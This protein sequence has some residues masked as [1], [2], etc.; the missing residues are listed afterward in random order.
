MQNSTTS[1]QSLQSPRDA[2]STVMWQSDDPGTRRHLR[3]FSKASAV[4]TASLPETRLRVMPRNA[5]LCGKSRVLPR[6][7]R[8]G[9]RFPGRELGDALAHAVDEPIRGIDQLVAVTTTS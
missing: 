9:Y 2:M 7:P 1:E 6:C 5:A 8:L 3:Y 4:E